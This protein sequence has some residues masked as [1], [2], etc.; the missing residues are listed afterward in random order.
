MKA[1]EGMRR[2]VKEIRRRENHILSESEERQVNEGE[3]GEGRMNRRV[4]EMR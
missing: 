1:S 4:K 2:R 3:R